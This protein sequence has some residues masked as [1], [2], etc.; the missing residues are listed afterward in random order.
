VISLLLTACGSGLPDA[1]GTTVQFD[2]V[3]LAPGITVGAVPRKTFDYYPFIAFSI[4]LLINGANAPN[5]FFT[6]G[7]FVQ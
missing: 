2:G 3:A 7:A 4:A 5:P 1:V 6:I